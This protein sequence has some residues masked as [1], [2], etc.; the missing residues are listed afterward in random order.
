[1]RREPGAGRLVAVP[2]PRVGRSSAESAQRPFSIR[3]AEMSES[4]SA[5]VD[6][7]TGGD[8]SSTTNEPQDGGAGSGA[9]G[10]TAGKATV[11]WIVAALVAMA[12]SY[13]TAKLVTETFSIPLPAEHAELLD[14]AMD[15]D[16]QAMSAART[17]ENDYS[18]KNVARLIASLAVALGVVLGLAAGLIHGNPVRGLIGAAAGGILALLLTLVVGDPIVDLR[19]EARDNVED[20]DTYGILVHVAQWVAI[21]IPVAIAIGIGAGSLKGGGKA[22]L[23]MLIGAALGGTVYIIGGGVVAPMEN[24]TAVKPPAGTP[25]AMWSLIPPF[26]AGLVLIR[27][28]P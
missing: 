1:M 22:L 7:Q 11:T 28:K 20:A 2:A 19:L 10:S 18:G 24:L 12:V 27:A 13:V 4:E 6:P 23:A 26:L 8:P 16:D 5:P 21:G 14:S 15:D 9:G 3:V 25:L 17:M